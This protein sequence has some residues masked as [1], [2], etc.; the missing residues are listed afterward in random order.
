MRAR[1]PAQ[2]AHAIEI[3]LG[4]TDLMRVV[5][6]FRIGIRAS[7]CE[8][9]A[10]A[11]GASSRPLQTGI[12][13]QWRSSFLAERAF[14]VLVFG[15]VL[16]LALAPLARLCRSLVTAWFLRRLRRVGAG[17]VASGIYVVGTEARA[18]VVTPN[19]SL[20]T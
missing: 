17:S 6:S 5:E 11:C 10:S 4:L 19:G 16:A 18:H 15:P 2:R 7:D 3:H 12:L 13:R 20:A 14:P 1:V 8:A 9:I